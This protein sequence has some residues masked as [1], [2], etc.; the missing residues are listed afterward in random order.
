MFL[1]ILRAFSFPVLLFVF[2]VTID[3]G[4]RLYGVF[5]W[6]DIPMHFFGG[7]A[8][9]FTAVSLC[10]LLIEQKI[11]RSSSLFVVW[12][13]VIG[14]VGVAA[15]GWETLE[16]LGDQ[17]YG[18]RMQLSLADTMGDL[19]LGTLGGALGGLLFIKTKFR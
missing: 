10:K 8:I 5:P 19:L 2:H 7:V 18:T 13:G 11:V 16:F 1:R 9:A 17:V 12:L 4:F 14:V 15:L 3:Y 6:I